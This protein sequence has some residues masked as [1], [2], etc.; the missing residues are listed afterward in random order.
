MKKY[1]L[2]ALTAQQAHYFN[3]RWKRPAIRTIDRHVVYRDLTV[4]AGLK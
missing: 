3:E 2:I 4:P 1:A